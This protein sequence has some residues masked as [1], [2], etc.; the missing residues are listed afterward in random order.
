MAQAERPTSTA[1]QRPDAVFPDLRPDTHV[2]HPLHAQD[3]VWPETNCYVDLWIEVLQA[4]GAPPEAVLG[5]TVRQDFEGDQFTFFKF[6]I[7]DIEAVTG[8]DIQ[9]LAIFENPEDH[10]AVQVARGRLCLV[11]V[12]GFYL[13]DTRGVAYGTVHGKTTIAVNR[14]DIAN[15]RME[16]FHNAGYFALDGADF[17]GVFQRIEGPD[18]RRPLFLPYSE[19]VKLP[20]MRQARTDLADWARRRL[21][22]HLARR[23]DANP[24]AAFAERF[25]AEA[26]LLADR[27]FDAFHRYAFNTLRQVGANFELLASHLRWL[28]D[29]GSAARQAL[30]IAE[31]AKAA[32]FQ[33]ARAVSR[34]SFDRLG[35]ALDPAIAAWDDLMADLQVRYGG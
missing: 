34:R 31:T 32:Q 9:E 30:Q 8:A 5:F 20:P 25:P 16:Y 23:P 27:P 14:I 7:P 4:L 11:E 22:E 21:A 13:P 19:F 15:R 35:P 12:D 26:A 18:G 10:V 6:P 2:P 29:N 1:K 28:G 33:L 17:D 24:I 3:R